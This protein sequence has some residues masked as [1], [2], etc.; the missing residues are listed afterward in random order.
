VHLTSTGDA[1]ASL[2]VK[3]V[4]SGG[5]EKEIDPAIVT[6][7][8]V[9]ERGGRRR[10]RRDFLMEQAQD[11]VRKMKEKSNPKQ[12]SQKRRAEKKKAEKRIP[13]AS[14]EPTASISTPVTPEKEAPVKKQK[15]TKPVLVEIVPNVVFAD[16][17]QH[18]SPLSIDRALAKKKKK[19]QHDDRPMPQMKQPAL[20]EDRKKHKVASNKGSTVFLRKT[21]KK[22]TTVPPKL[23]K[24]LK[25][26][27]ETE[28]QRANEFVEKVVGARDADAEDCA[29][30]PKKPPR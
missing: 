5:T 1:V 13:S 25:Q 3:Y 11:V 7:H 4:V 24:A 21:V 28:V 22:T 27:Y 30:R 8:E 12:D 10:R 17:E 2:D 16:S 26:V 29:F 15:K 18:I 19:S 20:T 6:A 23:E 9:L 14:P